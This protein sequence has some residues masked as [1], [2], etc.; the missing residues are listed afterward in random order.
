MDKQEVFEL[1]VIRANKMTKQALNSDGNCA[2]RSP[3]GPCL[4]GAMIKDEFYSED[5]ENLGADELIVVNALIAS[6]IEVNNSNDEQFLLELQ[7]LHDGLSDNNLYEAAFKSSLLKG[8]REFAVEYELEFPK[9][10]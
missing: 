2:Y 10:E 9:Y 3:S 4:I 5:M 8:L 6:G 7:E 1:A